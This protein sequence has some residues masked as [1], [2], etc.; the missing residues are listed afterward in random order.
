MITHSIVIH[1]NPPL[2]PP[3]T[4]TYHLPVNTYAGNRYNQ[5]LKTKRGYNDYISRMWFKKGDTVIKTKDSY[6]FPYVKAAHRRIVDIQEIIH[7][8]QFDD[9]TGIPKCILIKDHEGTLEWVSVGEIFK[10]STPKEE[11]VV[12][13]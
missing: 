4:E 3:R 8:V 9:V 5:H 7:L 11:F 10:L 2:P 6:Q 1:K 12:P 13:L